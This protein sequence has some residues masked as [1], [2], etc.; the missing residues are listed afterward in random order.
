MAWGR[1][2]NP[3]PDYA[4]LQIPRCPPMRRRFVDKADLSESRFS[5]NRCRGLPGH[6]SQTPPEPSQVLSPAILQADAGETPAS[7]SIKVRRFPGF[8]PRPFRAFPRPAF[9]VHSPSHFPGHFPK[10]FPKPSQVLSP[11]MLLTDAGDNICI[12]FDQTSSTGNF[13]RKPG[14]IRLSSLQQNSGLALHLP[15]RRRC[16]STHTPHATSISRI[17]L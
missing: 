17:R 15:A 7:A 2:A 8:F 1:I 9:P 6:L 5:P 10:P 14:R 4:G 11:A 13:Y 16:R 3:L 12:G